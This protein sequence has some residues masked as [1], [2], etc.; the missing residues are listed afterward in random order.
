MSK[1]KDVVNWR[2]RKKQQL[3]T[4]KG[5][6]CEICGYDKIEFPSVFCFHHIDPS[7]K[8]FGITAK[9]VKFESIL[10]EAEKCMLLCANCHMEIHD[11]LRMK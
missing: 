8:L 2:V 1:G 5:G 3:I 9:T 10:A 7:K 6:K 11:K 4:Y